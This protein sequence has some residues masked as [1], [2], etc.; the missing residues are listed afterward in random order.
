MPF[1]DDFERFYTHTHLEKG[2]KK[3]PA[4]IHFCSVAD[5]IVRDLKIG[6]S[7]NPIL[8]R[9]N[10]IFCMAHHLAYRTQAK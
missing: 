2:K 7:V 3:N 1:S 8:E 4:L 5:E 6:F 9:R 10:A